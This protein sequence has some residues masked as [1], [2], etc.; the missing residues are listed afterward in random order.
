[1]FHESIDIL[2]GVMYYYVNSSR[3]ASSTFVLCI[4]TTGLLFF[5]GEFYMEQK[6]FLTIEEQL[7]LLESRGLI[8]DNVD[9]ASACLA[10][11]NYYRLSGY[12]LTLRKGNRFYD[13]VKFSDVMQIYNFDRELKMLLSQWLEDIEISLRTRVGHELGRISP[14]SY[15]DV[16][17]FASQLHFNE[18]REELHHALKNNKNEAFVKH[19]NSK[20]D[21]VLPCWAIVET[22]SFGALSRLFCNLNVSLKKEVCAY[23]SNIRYTYF[24]NWFEG[25]V[26]LRNMCAHHTRLYNRGLPNALKFPHEDFRYFQEIGFDQ[27]A[28]GKKVFFSIVILDRICPENTPMFING[29]KVLIEKYPFIKIKHY[30]FPNDWEDVLDK[31]NK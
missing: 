27:N 28:I 19:H 22:L 10:R 2:D 6:P 29:I 16:N 26:V 8:I 1:M 12:T 30:G 3:R 24:E 15:L 11:L 7:D 9:N 31:I 17:S 5:A 25:L 18:F 14:T 21:G 20:Y 13:N 23:Y 4:N